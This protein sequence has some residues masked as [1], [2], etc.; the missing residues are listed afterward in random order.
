MGPAAF[1]GQRVETG[2]NVAIFLASANR[3]EDVFPEP[4]VLDFHR[5]KSK[6][7]AFGDWIHVCIGQYLAR[8]TTKAALLTLLK[9]FDS[10]ELAVPEDEIVYRANFNLRGPKHLPIRPN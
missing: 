6:H 9:E 5:P 8:I 10:F 7:L 3:D 4:D 1:H 2:Q